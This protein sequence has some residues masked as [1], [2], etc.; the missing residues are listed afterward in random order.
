MSKVMISYL[1]KSYKFVD[2]TFFRGNTTTYL[3]CNIKS[4]KLPL[5]EFKDDELI[6]E[7][8]KQDYHSIYIELY[9]EFRNKSKQKMMLLKM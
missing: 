4:N 3:C 5:D 2:A 6:N 7:R 9:N 1:F 8:N